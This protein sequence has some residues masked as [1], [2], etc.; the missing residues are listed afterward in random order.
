MSQRRSP[1]KASGPGFDL[2]IGELVIEGYA[3]AE[4]RAI[5]AALE[6][7]LGELLAEG[8]PPFGE[9]RGR[10]TGEFAFDRLDAGTVTHPAGASPQAVGGSAARAIV[11]RLRALSTGRD[12]AAGQRGGAVSEELP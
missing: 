10:R 9:G 4:G 2:R 7:E 6:Q 8:S 3:P 11:Q 12:E 5:A 1:H